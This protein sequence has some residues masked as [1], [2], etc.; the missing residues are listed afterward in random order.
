[1]QEEPEPGLSI[2]AEHLHYIQSLDESPECY[3]RFFDALLIR[4]S[5][6]AD[7]FHDL[8]AFR[9]Q[10]V[11]I[12]VLEPGTKEKF[13]EC[14]VGFLG[15][16]FA[17]PW[18]RSSAAH[19]SGWTKATW[20]GR[21]KKLSA[22]AKKEEDKLHRLLVPIWIAFRRRMFP[23][24]D[25]LQKWVDEEPQRQA[26][27]KADLETKEKAQATKDASGPSANNTP[28]NIYPELSFATSSAASSAAAPGNNT[29]PSNGQGA[30]V[31]QMFLGVAVSG[32][33]MSDKRVK[34][35]VEK[36]LKK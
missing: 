32:F 26:A 14:T 30:A 20:A 11:I 19:A 31:E 9:E 36:K 10:S 25:L 6:H 27:R 23:E 21:T 28:P 5:T 12:R 29:T 7:F 2:S 22:E 33:I 34:K 13:R 18:C 1:L 3:A 15:S 4:K 16:R 24:Q 17:H 8:K 35:Y